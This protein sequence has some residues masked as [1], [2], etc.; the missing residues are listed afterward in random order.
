MQAGGD[1]LDALVVGAGPTGLTLACE[2]LRRGLRIRVIDSAPEASRH[3][4]ALVLHV[5]SQEVLEQ[6]GLAG[7]VQAR[8]AAPG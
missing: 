5:R 6:M 8:G 3:S 4:K 2:L 1:R 7:A